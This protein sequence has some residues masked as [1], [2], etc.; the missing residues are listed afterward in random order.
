[1]PYDPERDQKIKD[2]RKGAVIWT[3][4][5]RQIHPYI[6]RWMGENNPVEIINANTFAQVGQWKLDKRKAKYK[7]KTVRDMIRE[8]MMAED[9]PWEHI[10][11][12][13]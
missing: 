11:L 2:I 4:D 1:M 8:R 9:Y 5:P 6:I 10:W 7:T 3:Y 13:A 12:P